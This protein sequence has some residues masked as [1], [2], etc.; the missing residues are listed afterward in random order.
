MNAATACA[1]FHDVS[2]FGSPPPTAA[3]GCASAAAGYGCP[4]RRQ[5]LALSLY[6]A[7]A[8]HATTPRKTA[9]IMMVFSINMESPT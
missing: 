6:R 5:I 3:S 1:A 8:H 4:L 2:L 9:R 7:A